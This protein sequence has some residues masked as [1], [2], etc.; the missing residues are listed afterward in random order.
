M[1]RNPSLLGGEG[2]RAGGRNRG[3]GRK[4][5]RVRGR[6]GMPQ[7]R[8]WACLHPQLG[9]FLVLHRSERKKEAVIK[10]GCLAFPSWRPARRHDIS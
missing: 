8:A 4:G 3:R 7:A 2:C 10:K 1:K 5:G 6:A 9:S